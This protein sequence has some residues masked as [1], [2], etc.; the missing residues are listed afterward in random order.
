MNH[1]PADVLYDVI[2][3][4]MAYDTWGR[5]AKPGS[6]VMNQPKQVREILQKLK[7]DDIHDARHL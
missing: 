6:V 1:N 4:A 3:Q 7:S 5:F 2:V